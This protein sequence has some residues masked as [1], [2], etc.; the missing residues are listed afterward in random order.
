MVDLVVVAVDMV[1][2]QISNIIIQSTV[3]R[4]ALILHSKHTF[5][6][7]TGFNQYGNNGDFSPINL[8]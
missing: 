1:Q 5:V 2:I 3:A 8:R 6:P 4:Y 7:Q